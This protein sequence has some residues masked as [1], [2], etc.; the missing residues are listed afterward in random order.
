MGCNN[1]TTSA[2]S[3]ELSVTLDRFGKAVEICKSLISRLPF[4][5]CTQN[6]SYQQL[7]TRYEKQEGMSLA[8]GRVRPSSLW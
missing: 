4:L 8:A 3:T 6:R 2:M 1:K 5:F 7:V